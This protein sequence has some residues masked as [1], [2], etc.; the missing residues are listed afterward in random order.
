[1]G[2]GPDMW[3]QGHKE[4]ST[5]DYKYLL[6][7]QSPCVLSSEIYVSLAC[8]GSF[9]QKRRWVQCSARNRRTVHQRTS[10]ARRLL[11]DPDVVCQRIGQG[12]FNVERACRLS[13]W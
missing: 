4:Y 6:S 11:D 3:A 9:L 1:M 5:W 13:A 8:R 10:Q 12:T 7:G 2:L